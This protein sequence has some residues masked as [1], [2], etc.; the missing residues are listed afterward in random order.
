MSTSASIAPLTSASPRARGVLFGLSAVA[1]W[2]GYL[3][4][5]R[6]GVASG[7]L[8]QD[9]VFLRYGTAGLL[10]LP[11]LLRHRP[12][13][14]GG[15]GWRR[16]LVLALVAGPLFIF[17]GVGG[18]VFAPLAHG[19]VIQPSTI[20]LASMLAAWLVLGERMS[21]QR[22]AGTAVIVAGLAVIAS[23]GGAGAGGQAW[24]GDLLFVA[25]GLCWTAFTVLLRRWNLSA[26]PA[27]AAVAVVSA[28]VVVPAF[29]LFGSL[30]RLTALDTTTLLTQLVVQGALSGV[31]AVLAYGASVKL[32]GAS[33]AALFPALVPAAALLAGVPIVGELPALRE[34][35][36][37][38]VATSGLAVAMGALRLP[39]RGR[40]GAALRPASAPSGS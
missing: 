24:I 32:L 3:A 17:L 13:T 36:G 31:L 30:S 26:L 15:V 1:M 5:A 12:R 4:Y 21:A 39:L 35:L 10:L 9:F 22:L 25:G 38:L 18:Y 40:L 37:A 2:A 29:L 7:L 14:L 6:A 33:T 11:W 28:L 20:T 16:G 23:G 19:A 8:P 27:T 34:A